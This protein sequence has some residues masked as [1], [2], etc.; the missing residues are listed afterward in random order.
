MESTGIITIILVVVNILMSWKGFRDYAFFHR[1]AFDLHQVRLHKDY[2][3]FVTSAFLH[4]GWMHLIF[5]MVALY[6]FGALLE[7]AAGPLKFLGIYFFS[8][9]SG[10]LLSLFVHRNKSSYISIGASGAVS[11]IV[12]ATIA[13]FPD[14][15]MGLLFIPIHL[16]SWL[17]G[18]LYVIYCMFGIRSQRDNIG[19]DAHLAGGITGLIL[20]LAMYPKVLTYN[21]FP[22]LLILLPSLV[23][24]FLVFTRPDFLIREKPFSEKVG[25]LTV[26]DR[27]NASRKMKEQ[28]LNRLLD[29]I[30]THGIN[31]LS[32]KEKER[33]EELSKV[34]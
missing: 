18:L 26:E 12:F 16:P 33:L 24:L 22:I 31:A 28:E 30:S 25:V 2:K 20:I 17:F 34:K 14:M 3:R 7:S 4:S 27:Y 9:V 21:Y 23:F 5:N 11:G 32:K 6:S 13:L 10:N 29:K 1:Y 19:H 8:L 15:S